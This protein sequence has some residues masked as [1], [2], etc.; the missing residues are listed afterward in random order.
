MATASVPTN[1]PEEP[2]VRRVSTTAYYTLGVLT[3]VLFG[4]LGSWFWLMAPT[5]PGPVKFSVSLV[6]GAFGSALPYW[7]CRDSTRNNET[8]DQLWNRLK[9]N[10]GLGII[11][12][13]GMAAA[14][15]LS[16]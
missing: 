10:A 15:F 1:N 2:T 16:F 7:E 4:A 8:S 11:L 9:A 12:N 14:Y 5:M 13:L 6:I 3:L